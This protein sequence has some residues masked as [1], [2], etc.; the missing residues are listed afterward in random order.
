MPTKPTYYI[1]H[2]R[3]RPVRTRDRHRKQKS[4]SIFISISI[5]IGGRC[6]KHTHILL[7]SRSFSVAYY[8]YDH[9]DA[10]H[11]GGEE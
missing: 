3:A 2:E 10:H 7:S 4:D 8:C 11:R 6:P 1:Y 5:H 9:C